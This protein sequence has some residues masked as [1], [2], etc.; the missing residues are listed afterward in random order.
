MRFLYCWPDHIHCERFEI[1]R[2]AEFIRKN[3]PFA[4]SATPF[5][6]LVEKKFQL[7]DDRN[8]AF[9]F[10]ALRF[11]HVASPD[12]FF[13]SNFGSVV[14]L[15]SESSYLS[16]AR[17]GEGRRGEYRR[18]RLGKNGQHLGFCSNTV[19]RRRAFLISSARVIGPFFI[20]GN[21]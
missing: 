14:V 11:V 16:L 5:P 17:A 2:I 1:H 10:R 3:E 12:G 19:G 4:W 18:G 8:G 9:A 15:P 20:P 21:R 6:V 7:G 13:H